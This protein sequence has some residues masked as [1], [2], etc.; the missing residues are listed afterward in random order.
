MRNSLRYLASGEIVYTVAA[1]A[2]IFHPEERRQRF[3]VGQHSDDIT[4][5]AVSADGTL[6]ATGERGPHPV[7]YVW[8][9]DTLQVKRAFKGHTKGVAQLAFSADGRRL[10]SVGSDNDHTVMVHC[11][12]T[13]LCLGRQK[14]D[15]RA[16]L[17]VAC[18][19]PA[20]T[21][22]A[23][24]TTT[25]TSPAF[26]TVGVR[27]AY[28]WYLSP[29]GLRRRRA[30]LGARGRQQTLYSAAF[31]PDGRAVVGTRDGNLYV[32][33]GQDRKLT[34]IVRAHDGPVY[35]VF[36]DADGAVHSGGGDCAAKVWSSNLDSAQAAALGAA[37]RSIAARPG[38]GS[39]SGS[40]SDSGSG[41]G[42]GTVLVGTAHSEVLELR[43]GTEAAPVVHTAGHFAGEVWGV[44]TSPAHD[45]YA[46][47]GD[48][49]TVRLWNRSEHRLVASTDLGGAVR[50]AAFSPDGSALA[51]GMGGG[52]KFGGAEEEEGEEDDQAGAFRV[53][54]GSTLEVVFEGQDATEWIQDIKFS[55]EGKLMAVSSHDNNIYL[56]EV[57]PEGEFL[58]KHTLSGHTSYV[59]HMDFTAD[60]L[61]LQSTSGDNELLYVATAV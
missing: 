50:A 49:G 44:A 1:V 15:C 12:D 56:Y 23:G 6:V 8:D 43:H 19:P 24:D 7:I 5:L 20:A 32:W 3:F 36:V 59:T 48:D 52:G 37:V 22:A 29:R 40:G 28:F 34:S 30:L 14:G 39:G 16:I 35:C 21:A 2:V 42:S 10:V 55:P 38:S 33:S 11:L 9:A 4:A 53:L 17:G 25:T 46:T 41:S 47:T 45:T 31:L 18:A 54:D 26:I 57:D 61:F 13:K 60:G 58:L 27:H 51:V